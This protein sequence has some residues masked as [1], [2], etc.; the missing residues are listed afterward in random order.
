MRGSEKNLQRISGTRSLNF[1][2]DD[3][4][5]QWAPWQFESAQLAAGDYTAAIV[6]LQKRWRRAAAVQRLSELWTRRSQPPV[7]APSPGS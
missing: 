7:A 1:R 2:T 3:R 4:K 6:T 5:E